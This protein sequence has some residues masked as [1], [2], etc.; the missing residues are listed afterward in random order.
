MLNYF[1]V[2]A[3]IEKRLVIDYLNAEIALVC[4]RQKVIIHV[5]NDYNPNYIPQK[6]YALVGQKAVLF[7]A[8]GKI[9][10]LLRSQ[11]GGAGGKWSLP[12]GGI[13]KNEDPMASIYREVNEETNLEMI[14]LKP[15]YLKSYQQDDDFIIIIAYTAKYTTGEIRLNWEHDDHKWVTKED[16]LEMDLT[17]DARSIIEKWKNQEK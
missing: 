7:N 12:G 9:L 13:D 10:V 15:F 5:M 6:A 16:A 2:N 17:S 11:K 14:R 1:G 3:N 4:L 8:E